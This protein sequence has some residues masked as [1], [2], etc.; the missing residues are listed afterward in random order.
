MN[1][2]HPCVS[3]IIPTYNRADVIGDTLAALAQQTVTPSEIIVVNDGSTD[4]TAAL[5]QQWTEASAGVSRRHVLHQENAG[6]ARARNAG[7]A[8][9][10]S[11][12][13]AFLGDDT[14][15]DAGWLKAHMERHRIVGEGCAVVGYTDWD[16]AHMRVTPYLRYIN[17]SGAQFGY[18][19]MTP[20]EEVPYTCLYTSNLSLPRHWLLAHPFNETFPKAMWEDTELGYRLHRAGLR[21]IYEAQAQTRHRHPL[22]MR[23]FLQRQYEVG[24]RV[25]RL[26]ELHPE[27]APR[28][29]YS[30]RWWTAWLRRMGGLLSC[31]HPVCFW[32]DR[33]QIPLPRPLYH[34]LTGCTYLQ[35]LFAKT[36]KNG[37]DL[38][39]D[40]KP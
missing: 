21:L 28:F 33:H 31:F 22:Q 19:Y 6:P 2:A 18:G 14:V 15:P 4:A 35:G 27:L 7:V 40:K 10:S 5:L 32:L 30:D 16:A 29:T 23:T 17:A 3:V 38:S 26:L 9:A 36:T 11:E 39:V 13:I 34:A 8:A 20:G 12:Y 24:Q 37:V 1:S 25:H